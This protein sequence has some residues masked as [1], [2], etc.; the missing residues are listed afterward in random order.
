MCLNEVMSVIAAITTPINATVS[1]VCA[2]VTRR[3]TAIRKIIVLT[4][5][6]FLFSIASA[7]LGKV[8]GSTGSP[9]AAESSFLN[10]K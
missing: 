7:G 4:M 6:S 3:T 1:P 10:A 8:A 9:F 2:C 5:K